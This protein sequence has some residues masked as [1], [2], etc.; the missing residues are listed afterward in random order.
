MYADVSGLGAKKRLC[1]ACMHRL[2]CPGGGLMKAAVFVDFQT[3]TIGLYTVERRAVG[4][5]G[6]KHELQK[7]TE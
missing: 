3:R 1:G 5:L 2:F 7:S 4:Q 6:G